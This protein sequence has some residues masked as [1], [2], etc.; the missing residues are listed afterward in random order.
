[1]LLYGSMGSLFLPKL[2]IERGSP[3]AVT[4]VLSRPPH[5]T[6]NSSRSSHPYNVRK[7]RPIPMP[8]STITSTPASIS[9]IVIRSSSIVT[10][11]ATRRRS[12][13]VQAGDMTQSSSTHRGYHVPAEIISRAIWL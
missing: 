7:R 12:R 2:R 4:D 5:T 3:V 6:N 8:K 11:I 1:M 10:S 9:A 13:A